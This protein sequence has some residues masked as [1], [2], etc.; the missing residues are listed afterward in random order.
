MLG[1]RDS[2]RA[3]TDKYDQDLGNIFTKSQKTL[4]CKVLVGDQGMISGTPGTI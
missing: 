1:F 2:K 4:H 3:C